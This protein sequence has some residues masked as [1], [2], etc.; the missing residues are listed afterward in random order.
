MA[1]MKFTFLLFIF[2]E[3]MFFFT[4]FWAFFDAALSPRV[5]VGATWAPIGINPVNPI[6]L[7]LYNTLVLL[8]SRWTL[9]WAHSSLLRGSEGIEGA[10]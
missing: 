1:A 10:V 9:T 2:R 8:L 4:I 6:G 5:E 3:F 7:P